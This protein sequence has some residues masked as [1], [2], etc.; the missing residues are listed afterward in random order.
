MRNHSY[1]LALL[2]LTNCLFSQLFVSRDTINVI[3]NGV[4]LK[5]PWANGLNFS[6]ISNFDLDLD[7]VNDD[8]L[9]FDRVN[10]FGVGRFRCFIKTG[11]AGQPTY[12]SNPNLS[13]NF[14]AIS[15][16]AVGR[17]YDCDGDMDLFCSTSAGIT[18]YKNIST[19]IIGL[20]FVL[21]KALIYS[22]FLPQIANLYASS[23]AVPG[24]ADID[25]DGDLDILTFSPNGVFIEYHKN[26]SKETYGI[27]DS[28]NKFELTTN[29]WG[30]MIENNCGIDLNQNCA[31]K[32]GPQN[33]PQPNNNSL[34]AG[35]CLTCLDS[36]NDG[37]QD[38]ILGDISCNILQFAFNGG[39][40]T[41]AIITDTT[42]LYP[43]YPLKANT[44]QIK[45]NNFPCAYYV[46]VDADNKKDL[47]ATPNS[48]GSENTQSVWYYKNTSLTNT[49]NFQFV[50][51]NLLQDQMIEVGQNSFP[52]L[53]D[54]DADGKK[55]LLIGTYGYYNVNTLQAKLTLYKNI[56]TLAQPA[57]S[58]ITRDYASVLSYSLNNAIPTVGDIDN[59]GDIDILIGTQSG[60]IHWLKNTAG[61]GALCTFTFLSNPFGF[62]NQ[63]PAAAAPQLF[64]I[65]NDN[66]LDLFVGSKTGKIS[67]YKNIGLP[68]VPSFTRLTN[69]FGNVNVQGDVNLYG[70]D[71]YASPHFFTENGN[72]KL[73]VGSISGQIFYYSVPTLTSSTCVLISANANGYNEGGQSSVFFEDVNADGKRDL[74]VGNGSG[75]LSF[76]SSMGPDVGLQENNLQNSNFINLFP[77]PANQTF[78]ISVEKIEVESGQV[79]VIDLFGKEIIT[80][81]INSNFESINVNEL[82]S[83]IYFVKISINN[84]SGT[85]S[86][87]KKLIKE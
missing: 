61:P 19:P 84:H 82:N 56:G 26:L 36:D 10:Q 3:E 63:D 83:G 46:D 41:T 15:N 51:K 45:L 40:S 32:P 74:F 30:K 70:P 62:T 60:Q 16:W 13:Y 86:L 11:L 35:S 18:V 7:G 38:L 78:N 31:F 54:Y 81:K 53:F 71:G 77:N 66:L 17:D 1:L 33:N 20:K 29:C 73:L 12:S 39:T 43:N 27:C 6:N 58:L 8:I 68:G 22:N 47:I 72:T 57:Y 52:V 37:D 69:F 50:K 24:I 14:P 87:I 75:G 65:D 9:A 55:D 76:Y 34:H 85:V 4:T 5:M 23:N 79:I 21:A 28:L 2:L 64:D 44:Q 48:N 67:Y 25:G 59:D 80:K 49:V 42:R